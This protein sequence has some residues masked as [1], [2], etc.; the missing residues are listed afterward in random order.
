MVS[1]IVGTA[2]TGLLFLAVVLFMARG[3]EWRSYQ[4]SFGYE[5]ESPG[6]AVGRWLRQPSTWAF[7]FVVFAFLI[8]AV[9]LA[10]LGALP[11]PGPGGMAAVGLVVGLLVLV[12]A[13]FGTYG[14][15]RSRDRTTAEAVVVSL[16]VFATMFVLFLS[17]NLV[18]DLLGS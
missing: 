1:I 4:F 15:V 9:A 11:L 6:Q 14:F 3:M 17:A 7:G 12:A 10:A 2:V 18:F 16:F 5:A 13:V 8:A